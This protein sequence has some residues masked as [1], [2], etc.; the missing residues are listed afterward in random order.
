GW[1]LVVEERV[2][3]DVIAA[4]PAAGPDFDRLHLLER[5][6]LREH[7]LDA[8]TAEDGRKDTEFHRDT[9]VQTA[10][11]RWL[12]RTASTTQAE[13]YPSSKVANAGGRWSDIFLPAAMNP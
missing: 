11:R 9:F 5:A 7:F 2:E 1:R 4:G 12:S 13:S 10:P 3:V 8:E 6:D